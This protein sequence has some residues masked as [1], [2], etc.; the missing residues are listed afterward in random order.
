MFQH[1]GACARALV[2]G[3]SGRLNVAEGLRS[4]GWTAV[5]CAPDEHPPISP[6]R[7]TGNQ[8]GRMN[9]SDFM[10]S[11]MRLLERIINLSELFLQELAGAKGPVV[12]GV[13][14]AITCGATAGLRA[15]GVL[16]GVALVLD[17]VWHLQPTARRAVAAGHLRVAEEERPTLCVRAAHGLRGGGDAGE[18]SDADPQGLPRDGSQAGGAG[19]RGSVRGAAGACTLVLHGGRA[20]VLS[21]DSARSTR[22]CKG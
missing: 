14:S 3:S 12:E 22:L 11:M 21:G 2:L 6:V 19:E 13:A 17:V 16:R 18:P 4:S 5:E 8:R 10:N 7:M 1:V 20:V 9:F 15:D